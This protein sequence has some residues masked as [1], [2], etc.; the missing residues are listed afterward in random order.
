MTDKTSR[1]ALACL[2]AAL[3]ACG[4]DSQ[5]DRLR[6]AMA[7]MEEAVEARQAGDFVEYVSDDFRGERGA[8]DRQSL[9][10]FLVGQ[11]LGAERIEVVM[12]S[13]EIVLHS[14]ERATVTMDAWVTG[15]RYFGDRNER[16]HLVS[17]WRLEGGEWRC[18]SA[19]T[20]N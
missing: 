13:P 14:S 9:R 5:E 3:A 2:C 10:G 16:L 12:G 7:A 6:A 19:E 18:Y 15:G 4:S 17:G 1:L 8:F 11:M 20:G